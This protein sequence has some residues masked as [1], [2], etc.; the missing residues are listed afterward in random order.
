[1]TKGGFFVHHPWGDGI[2]LGIIV[3]TSEYTQSQVVESADHSSKHCPSSEIMKRSFPAEIDSVKVN[4]SPGETENAKALDWDHIPVYY[5]MH[6][7]KEIGEMDKYMVQQ[8]ANMTWHCQN[9]N[10][11]HPDSLM[12]F[13][14]PH[15]SQSSLILSFD[16]PIA[17][18]K[19]ANPV[20]ACFFGG[21]SSLMHTVACRIYARGY[22]IHSI[23]GAIRTEVNKRK[24]MAVETTGWVFPQGALIDMDIVS[25]VPQKDMDEI[26]YEVDNMSPT[27]MNWRNELP[28]LYGVALQDP[29]EKQ[30]KLKAKYVKGSVVKKEAPPEQAPV[31]R[32]CTAS[33]T[34]SVNSSDAESVGSDSTRSGRFKNFGLL[35]FFWKLAK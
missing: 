24:V 18:G 29:T 16:K 8:E 30:K 33:S 34:L 13:Q 17:S 32:N 1:M 26:L 22:K 3:N 27:M 35:N 4:R 9:E 31:K 11:K 7:Y 14:F 12:S 15:D 25:N 19:Y 10:T 20:Q 5:D 21:L 23:K 2:K 28:F 6:R